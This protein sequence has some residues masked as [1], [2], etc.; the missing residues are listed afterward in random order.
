MVQPGHPSDKGAVPR[1]DARPPPDRADVLLGLPAASAGY[2]RRAWAEFQRALDPLAPLKPPRRPRVILLSDS[3]RPGS[4]CSRRAPARRGSR[5]DGHA[6]RLERL[7]GL[8]A[9][10]LRATPSAQP[11]SA[12]TRTAPPPRARSRPPPARPRRVARSPARRRRRGPR[13]RELAETP[14]LLLHE[15]GGGTHAL[16]VPVE[17][18]L[19]EEREQLVGV[20][21]GCEL[22]EVHAVHPVELGVVEG[23]G[24]APTRSR[25]KRSTSSSRDMIVVSPS[26]AQP[27]RA[28]KFISA[29]A[30]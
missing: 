19:A 27:S 25:S 21:G 18:L 13:T 2:R 12:P 30:M 22:A 26:G 5:G 10:P 14:D 3:S 28:R 24:L 11:R 17:P 15:R 4:S 8:Q 1:R 20:A 7:A 16:L 6:D 23:G 9:E 29:G